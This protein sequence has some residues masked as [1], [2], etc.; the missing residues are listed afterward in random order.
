MT[1]IGLDQMRP[2]FGWMCMEGWKEAV[3]V[4]IMFGWKSRR[5]DLVIR[6]PEVIHREKSLCYSNLNTNGITSLWIPSG[7]LTTKS[8]RKD[9][10]NPER[11]GVTSSVHPTLTSNQTHKVV[12]TYNWVN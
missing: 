6:D 12:E 8:A 4:F 9:E 7:S 5:A 11:D 10:V 1:W 3:T 2:V